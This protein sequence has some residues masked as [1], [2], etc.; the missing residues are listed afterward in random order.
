VAA[1]RIDMRIDAGFDK[2]A[3]MVWS[4]VRGSFLLFAV[5]VA[6]CGAPASNKG[7]CTR[8]TAGCPCTQDTDCSGAAPRCQPSTGSCVECLPASD[9]CTGGAH[10]VQQNGTY[11]CAMGCA[12]NSDCKG[13]A[14]CCGS[15]C[16]D[17]SSDTDNCG[18]C[19]NKC[20][21]VANG[22]PICSGGQCV[23]KC[24]DG[25]GDCDR[26]VNNGCETNLAGDIRNC[27]ACGN[28]CSGGANSS[29]T[30]AAGKCNNH[31]ATGYD[32]CDGNPANG[33]E[34]NLFA[35][36][37]NCGMCGSSCLGLANA[38]SGHCSN[39]MCA[40]GACKD[41]FADCDGKAITGCESNLNTDPAH[42]GDCGVACKLP[43]SKT[44]CVAGSCGIVSCDK[45]WG[46]CDLDPS[47]GCERDLSSDKANCGMCKHVCQGMSSSQSCVAGACQ[48]NMC[49]NGLSDCDMVPDNGC[50]SNTQ[51][52]ILNCGKCGA[53]C[54]MPAHTKV[55]C[56]VGM[57]SIIGC[58]VLF[59]DCDNNPNNGCETDLSSPNS[60]GACGNV[61]GAVANGMPGC[62]K[63]VCTPACSPGFANCDGNYNNGCEA[64]VDA[65]VNNCGACFKKCN[66]GHAAATCVKSTC[67]YGMCD[68]GWG[69]CNGK[70]ADGCEHDLTADAS[71]CGACGNVCP[72]NTPVC[73]AGK[74]SAI[75]LSGVYNQ[76]ASEGRNV[77]IWK[78]TQ[79]QDL[80]MA[81]DFCT[82]RGLAWWKP[83]SQA[84]AQKLVTTTANY[85]NQPL[86]VQVYGL[87]TDMNASTLGGYQVQVDSPGCV[88]SCDGT[89][90]GAF[91]RWGC[92]YCDPKNNQNQ[93]CCWD[94]GNAN[95]WFPCED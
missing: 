21:P 59:A 78:T 57:C 79:C 38:T 3:N 81:T 25:F 13:G 37:A 53:A 17:V 68:P 35:D 16:L 65:D 5:L 8:G 30:C 54:M 90:F 47:N 41:G 49:L 88:N 50:E 61:C 22:T 43:H 94:K 51:T 91:R 4:S 64:P 15:A 40:I 31:C 70:N 27:G 39:G 66:M 34:A 89:G 52:D 44:N 29:A 9:N 75:D 26:Q 6:G 60:C 63:G 67:V 83:K 76:Y 69:D 72:Q 62:V 58:D 2:E 71:N 32:D 33:C 28:L 42:C 12:T 19:G 86:W 20:R 10:C 95:D 80:T 74:C 18:A 82:K 55:S 87:K 1:A 48:I 7:A 73:L 11:A 24:S 46:D 14:I 85:I 45:N 84:D 56:W 23:A 77:Y 92:S 93:S 36:P